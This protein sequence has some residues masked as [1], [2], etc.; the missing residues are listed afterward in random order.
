MMVM[1]LFFRC[2]SIHNSV[3]MHTLYQ[4]TTSLA[5]VICIFQML[6]SF[7]VPRKQVYHPWPLQYSKNITWWAYPILLLIHNPQL[8]DIV[9]FLSN[10]NPP[11]NFLLESHNSTTRKDLHGKYFLIVD[12]LR[13]EFLEMTSYCRFTKQ[14]STCVQEIIDCL[15]DSNAMV[16]RTTYR[17]ENHTGESINNYIYISL[18]TA[19]LELSTTPM[20]FAFSVV[21]I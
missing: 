16:E 17:W 8:N 14:D 10:R 11:T 7:E 19:Y 1:V 18:S 4:H 12:T 9:W 21:K 5:I 15:R 6:S 13:D 3:N 2:I 20:R